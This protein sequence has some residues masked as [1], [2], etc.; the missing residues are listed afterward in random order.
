MIS[1]LYNLGRRRDYDWLIT[2]IHILEMLLRNM[3]SKKKGVK[4]SYSSE[5]KSF[6]DVNLTVLLPVTTVS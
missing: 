2:F 3:I 1:I 4:Y 6:I 5:R